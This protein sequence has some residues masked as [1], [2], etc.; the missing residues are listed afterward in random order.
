MLTLLVEVVFIQIASVNTKCVRE[1]G[2]GGAAKIVS[3]LPERGRQKESGH[4][5]GDKQ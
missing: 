1:R 2:G 4:L 3:C 5:I